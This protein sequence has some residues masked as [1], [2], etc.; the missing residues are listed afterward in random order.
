[1]SGKIDYPVLYLSKYIIDNKIEYYTLLR[2]FNIS[3]S[4]IIKFV[5]YILK[6]IE[7]TQFS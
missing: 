7:Y 5:Q 1:V 2:E 3:E 4:A 6:G